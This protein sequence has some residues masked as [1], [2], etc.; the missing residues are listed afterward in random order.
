MAVETIV[1]SIA[2]IASEAITAAMT[3]GLDV[4]DLDD[5]LP[6]IVFMMFLLK[7]RRFRT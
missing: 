5:R 1:A 3:S 7:W 2:T 4:A 6:N